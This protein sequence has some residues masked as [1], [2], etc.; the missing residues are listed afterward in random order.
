MKA[1]FSKTFPKVNTV[2]WEKENNGFEANFKENGKATSAV[3]DASGNWQET[4]RAIPIARIPAAA[5]VYL[6]AHYAGKKIKEAAELK[7][8]DGT[9]NFEAEVDG[10]DIIFDGNGKFL[11]TAKD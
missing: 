10:M 1:A 8:A 3:F 2:K 6:N 9:T 7:L 5:K 11:R 4:E